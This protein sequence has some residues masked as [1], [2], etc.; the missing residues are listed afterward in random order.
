MLFNAYQFIE[1]FFAHFT[2]WLLFTGAMILVED[3]MVVNLYSDPLLIIITP[4][5]TK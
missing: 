3:W 2:V 4:V 1:I 5:E